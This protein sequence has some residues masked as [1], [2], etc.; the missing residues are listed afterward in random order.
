MATG[1][2][3]GTSGV[4]D[5]L[6]GQMGKNH[7]LNF[8]LTPHLV[9]RGFGAGVGFDMGVTMA[10]N[11]DISVE[12]DAGPKAIAPVTFAMNFLEERLSLGASLKAVARGG[13]QHLFSI[14]DISAFGGDSSSS[15]SAGS[16]SSE[17]DLTD[18]VV[19][20]YG[21]GADVGMLFTPTK[22]MEPTLGVSVMDIGGTKYTKA[23]VGGAA[24]SAPETR[25]QAVNV[26]V[27]M[28]PINHDWFYVL[29]TVDAHQ[30][31][32]PFSYTKKLNFGA[33]LGL[34]DRLRLQAGLHQGYAS[35]GLQ[36]DLKF[37]NYRMVTLRAVTY[38]EELGT[39]AG[40]NEDRRYA[41]QIKI[42]M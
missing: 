35:G 17:S 9:F 28:K 11:R 14:Q 23:D 22:V 13:V 8:G 31:N 4:L 18:F 39:V 24:I 15:D 16:S 5:L 33:E 3:D 1:G 26:G 2:S 25:R 21:I 37:W 19:G 40:S 36:F 12:I 42:L 29:G 20:G 27:S 32:Q 6:Q 41:A 7:H 10:V 38:S 34:M 30:I